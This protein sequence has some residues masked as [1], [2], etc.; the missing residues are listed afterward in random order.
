MGWGFVQYTY[1]VCKQKGFVDI[2]R[3]KKYSLFGAFPLPT[4]LKPY[5][6]TG[7]L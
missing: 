7:F 1:P 5:P 4:I 2:M 3:Y 6:A